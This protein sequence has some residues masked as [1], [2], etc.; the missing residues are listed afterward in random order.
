MTSSHET[1]RVYSLSEAH[2]RHHSTEKADQCQAE[3]NT[4]KT[5]ALLT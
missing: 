3:E 4:M 1:D 5:T 2:P